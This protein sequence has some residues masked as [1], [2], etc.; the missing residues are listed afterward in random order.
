MSAVERLRPL[1][2]EGDRSFWAWRAEAG[3]SA[4]PALLLRAAWEQG[5][6]ELLC[7]LLPLLQ[8]GADCDEALLARY[9]LDAVGLTGRE[10]QIAAALLRY[11]MPTGRVV[12]FAELAAC[13][14]GDESLTSRVD[15]RIVAVHLARLRPK[16]NRAGVCIGTIP[17]RGYHMHRPDEGWRC[18]VVLRG[19]YRFTPLCQ[20][21]AS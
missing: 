12:G 1:D 6:A 18:A 21:G 9:G 10:S 13:V 7:S 20:R 2:R 11:G 15:R 8:G 17:Q 19:V 16:V 5:R 4:I 3:M 14:L